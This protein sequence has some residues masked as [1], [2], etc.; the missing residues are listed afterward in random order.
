MEISGFWLVALSSK[1]IKK[2]MRTKKPLENNFI[3]FD[4]GQASVGA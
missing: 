3:R 1:M 4:L 2:P